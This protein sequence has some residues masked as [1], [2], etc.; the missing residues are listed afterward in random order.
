M[1][2]L[3][4]YDVG[5]DAPAYRPFTLTEEE[6]IALPRAEREALTKEALDTLRIMRHLGRE[7][8]HR[9]KEAHR[10]GDDAQAAR[11]LGAM[12]RLGQ[13]NRGPEVMHIV[14]LVGKAIEQLADKALFELT[15]P[16]TEENT[17][18]P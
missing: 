16:D 18:T 9:A 13:A 5:A 12:K 11:L 10:N 2:V 17:R 15:A 1:L 3:K 7:L 4:L 14:D 6:A 8:H